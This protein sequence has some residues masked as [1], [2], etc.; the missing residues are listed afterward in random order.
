HQSLE[1]PDARLSS[2][3]GEFLEQENEQR[4]VDNLRRFW[5]REHAWADYQIRAGNDR[6]G[7]RQ[8]WVLSQEKLANF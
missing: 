8:Q 3:A 2:L 6:E 1:L 5:S 7:I 4:L